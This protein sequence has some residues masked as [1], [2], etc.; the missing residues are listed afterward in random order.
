MMN[1]PVAGCDG[2]N[3]IKC[4]VWFKMSSAWFKIARSVEPIRM[5]RIYEESE[6]LWSNL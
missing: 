4:L 3:K 1:H 2:V 5:E 6:W